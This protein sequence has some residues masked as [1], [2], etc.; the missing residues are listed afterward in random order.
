[1]GRWDVLRRCA[2]TKPHVPLRR[3]HV[4]Q[5]GAAGGVREGRGTSRESVGRGTDPEVRNL[6]L[7]LTGEGEGQF[8]V[9]DWG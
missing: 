1:M 6:Y 5:T 2:E 3:R 9:K 8:T 4:T 7:G